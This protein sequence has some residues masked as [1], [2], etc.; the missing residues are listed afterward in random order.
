MGFSGHQGKKERGKKMTE[1]KYMFTENEGY[2]WDE[3][4]AQHIGQCLL[5]HDGYGYEVRYNEANQTWT[6]WIS[7]GSRNSQ[8]GYGG[9]NEVWRFESEHKDQYD[10]TADIEQQVGLDLVQGGEWGH[11]GDS[12]VAVTMD[13]YKEFY[14]SPA[15]E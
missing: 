10:A 4:T 1:Q 11:A 5:V 8:R 15:D 9:F 6:L 14:E 7:S 12:V 13:D 2:T 3:Y